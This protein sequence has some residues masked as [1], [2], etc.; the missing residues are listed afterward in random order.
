MIFPSLHE[1]MIVWYGWRQRMV[2]FRLS[3]STP[4][5]SSLV[6]RR[7]EP[8]PPHSTIWNSWAPVRASFFAWKAK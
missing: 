1:T 3:L 5:Y 7:A 6:S 8:F 2:I 4:F